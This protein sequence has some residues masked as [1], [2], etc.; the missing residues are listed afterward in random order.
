MHSGGAAFLADET[1]VQN[2]TAAGRIGIGNPHAERLR[3]VGQSR[4]KFVAAVNEFQCGYLAISQA[5]RGARF[6]RIG[7]DVIRTAL[8]RPR[9]AVWRPWLMSKIARQA[10]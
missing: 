8:R 4:R 1:V 7:I 10:I 2:E 5:G 3:S 6:L 9:I